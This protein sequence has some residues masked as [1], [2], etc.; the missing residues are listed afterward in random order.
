MSLWQAF[1]GA[2]SRVFQPAEPPLFASL[3]QPAAPD[4]DPINALSALAKFVA[5]WQCCEIL[6]T[7][8]AGR[9]LLAHRRVSRTSEATEVDDP[10][11]DLLLERPN[12][13][14]SAFE[15]RRQLVID[16]MLTGNAYIW[17]PPSTGPGPAIAVYRLHPDEV[18]PE[19]GTLGIIALYRW[20][21]SISGKEMLLPPDQ[22]VHIRN[23]MW[24]VGGQA[25]V[26]E[27]AIRALHDDLSTD[28]GARKTAKEASA[29]GRPDILFSLDQAL[30][31]GA[32]AELVSMWREA[33]ARR[34][35]A[36]VLGQGAKATP[37]SWSPKDTLNIERVQQLTRDVFA[38]F[39]VPLS[40]AGY[41][42]GS[43][44]A[45]ARQTEKTYWERLKARC[46][47]FDDGFSQLAQPGVR[48]SHDFDDVEALHV[49]RSERLANVETLV[50]LGAAPDEAAEYE[51]F[52]DAPLPH[53]APEAKDPAGM[54]DPS[55][56]IAADDESATDPNE[57]AERAVISAVVGAVATLDEVRA[58]AS[59]TD[60]GLIWS[61]QAQR[62]TRSLEEA[63]LPHAASHAAE[64]IATLRMAAEMGERVPAWRLSATLVRALREAHREPA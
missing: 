33:M 10:A 26:G 60:L 21:D 9:N 56:G 11:L 31:K 42:D 58:V 13:G 47:S 35:G 50:R 57:P 4:Y 51:G 59:G 12:I 18:T 20:T 63:G 61:W 6:S 32:G 40:R 22:V 55:S 54:D 41:E 5:V 52:T 36:F 49:S 27:S 14:F 25:G 15:F 19:V 34:D 53:E 44:Y 64:T 62:L 2:I 48:I 17:R 39:G 7:D 8:L 16:W 37:L 23:L 24:N 3:S 29:R 46:R 43:N 30:G 38:T 28:I 45:T 1:T